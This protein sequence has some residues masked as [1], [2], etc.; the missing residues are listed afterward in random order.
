MYSKKEIAVL[1]KNFWTS[2]GLY[3]K[4]LRN[5]EGNEVNWLNYKTGVRGIYFRMDA[6]IEKA[7][8]GIEITHDATERWKDYYSKFIQYKE[9]LHQSLSE[10]WIWQEAAMDEHNKTMSRIYTELAGVNILQKE[11]WPAIISFLKPRMLALDE[12]WLMAK[13]NFQQG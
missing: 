13:E 3:L 6:G 11:D 10:V 4:P 9:M 5:A 7:S 8:I 12:F 1:K 2:L